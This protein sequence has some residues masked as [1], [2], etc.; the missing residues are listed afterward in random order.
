MIRKIVLLFLLVGVVVAAVFGVVRYSERKLGLRGFTPASAITATTNVF[1]WSEAVEKVKEART[2]GAGA[3]T[4]PPELKHYS[5]RYWFLATQ[6]AE[7]EQHHVYHCQDFFDLA[8]LI[9]R[10]DLVVVPAVTDSYVLYGIGER[11]D[12]S[13]FTRY[14]AEPSPDGTPV[15][16]NFIGDYDSLAALAKNI[17]GRSFD[18]NNPAD[19][20]T[21]KIIMLSSVRPQTLKIIEEVADV[22]RRQFNRPLP[23]SSLVRPE[24]Y[25]RALR[26]VNRNAILIDTPPHSTGLAFDI[27]YRYMSAAEQNFV[28]N[29][30][31]RLK[32]EGRIEVIRERNANYHVFAFIDGARPPDDLIAA[33]LEKAGAPPKETEEEAAAEPPKTERKARPKATKTRRPRANAR[34]RRR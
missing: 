33:S 26:R 13:E 10:G 15:P 32:R 25:Q 16:Q 19:R 7:V 6:V 30:L 23:V 2:E 29:E 22:Y 1:S 34:K 20:E 28:M 18:L 9:Q 27:D 17:A 31:A 3:I 14:I 21:L 5:E 11:A 4:T 12:D 8:A 24:Q